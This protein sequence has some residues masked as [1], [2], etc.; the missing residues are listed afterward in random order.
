[1]AMMGKELATTAIVAT[2]DAYL[3]FQIR[4]FLFLTL[5]VN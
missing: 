1:M 4:F 2:Q 5:F 3:V